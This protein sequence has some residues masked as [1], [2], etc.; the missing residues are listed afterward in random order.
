MNKWFV[1]FLESEVY[2]IKTMYIDELPRFSELRL[3]YI[4]DK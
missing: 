4:N 2:I 1:W 3:Y